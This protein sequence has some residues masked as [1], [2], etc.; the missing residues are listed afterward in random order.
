MPLAQIKRRDEEKKRLAQR[1]GITLIVVPFWW[2]GRLDRYLSHLIK[3]QLTVTVK[4]LVATIKRAQPD[5]LPTYSLTPTASP[6]PEEIPTEH[7]SKLTPEVEGVGQPS[8]ACFFT[9]SDVNPVNW[10]SSTTPPFKVIP[11]KCLTNQVNV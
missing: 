3:S 6:I 4:S 11:P 8:A 5:L 10:Y 9:L 2:D 1:S 7:I